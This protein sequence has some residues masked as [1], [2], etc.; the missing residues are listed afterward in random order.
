RDLSFTV[1]HP[2]SPETPCV[3]E[4]CLACEGV[5]PLNGEMKLYRNLLLILSLILARS[6][7]TFYS[8]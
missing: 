3:P 8:A 4:C 5:K 7:V 2:P 1:K 6:S